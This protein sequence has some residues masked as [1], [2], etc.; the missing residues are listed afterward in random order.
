MYVKTVLTFGDKPAPAMAQIALRKTA[1]ESKN[2]KPEAAK[3]LTENVYMDDIYESVE[4]VEEAKTLADDIDIVLKSGGFQVKGWM[5]NKNL[6]EENQDANKLKGN[7]DEKVLGIS[8]NREADT[9]SCQIESKLTS[10]NDENEHF[11]GAED[12]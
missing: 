10:P 9:L 1:Q 6:N 7:V 4:T 3:V 11:K 12:D 2:L 8:W 5:S